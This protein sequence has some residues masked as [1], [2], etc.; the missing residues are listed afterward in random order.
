[1]TFEAFPRPPGGVKDP[2]TRL[3]F[4]RGKERITGITGTSLELTHAPVEGSL[5]LT[6]NSVLVDV[7]NTAVCTVAGKTITLV[8]AAVADDVFVAYYNYRQ[9]GG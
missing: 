1:M 5:L 3:L 9:I 7:D 6:K 2:A 8:R 4:Q